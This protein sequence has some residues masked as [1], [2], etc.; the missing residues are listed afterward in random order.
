MANP[1]KGEIPLTLG[2]ETYKCRLTIDALVRI[3][4]EL[5]KGILELA[6]A[7]AVNGSIIF[8]SSTYY[9]LL[10]RMGTLL[11]ILLFA[12]LN[13]DIKRLLVDVTTLPVIL[14]QS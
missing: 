4:D 5:D 3:E 1:L 11:L 7:I 9:C 12:R 8:S 2:K 14:E 6:T 10:V 13:G